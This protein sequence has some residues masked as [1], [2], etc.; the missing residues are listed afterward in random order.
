MSNDRLVMMFMI[1]QSNTLPSI[2]DSNAASLSDRIQSTEAYLDFLLDTDDHDPNS[3]AI[4][5]NRQISFGADITPVFSLSDSVTENVAINASIVISNYAFDTNTPPNTGG[6]RVYLTRIGSVPDIG[7]PQA[8]ASEFLVALQSAQPFAGVTAIAQE[9]SSRIR[10]IQGTVRDIDNKI[11]DV[12]EEEAVFENEQFI[13]GYSLQDPPSDGYNISSGPTV[14]GQ[15]SQNLNYTS[16]TPEGTNVG[17]NVMTRQFRDAVAG[18]L[19]FRFK[20]RRTDSIAGDARLRFRVVYDVPGQ[21]ALDE[22]ELV[23]GDYTFMPSQ[24]T[25]VAIPI[26]I[27][28]LAD[29]NMSFFLIFESRGTIPAG[30]VFNFQTSTG[31]SA[32]RIVEA[33]VE[34]VGTTVVGN[35]DWGLLLG[36]SQTIANIPN[37]TRTAL[38]ENFS[39]IIQSDLG[40]QNILSAIVNHEDDTVRANIIPDETANGTTNTVSGNTV[41][42]SVRLG[43]N[44]N[45]ASE[46]AVYMAST[47]LLQAGDHRNLIRLRI[48]QTGST[49]YS[50]TFELDTNN[51]LP[52]PKSPINVTGDVT[53]TATFQ[54][55]FFDISDISEFSYIDLGFTPTVLVPANT[56]FEIQMAYVTREPD[57]VNS[58]VIDVGGTEVNSGD[59]GSLLSNNEL[60]R[61]SLRYS[62]LLRSLFKSVSDPVQTTN[63]QE[64]LLLDNGAV[65][66]VGTAAGIGGIPAHRSYTSVSSIAANTETLMIDSEMLTSFDIDPTVDEVF[67]LYVNR[68][69][70]STVTEVR[71]SLEVL[72]GTTWE[73]LEGVDSSISFLPNPIVPDTVEFIPVTIDTNITGIRVYIESPQAIPTNTVFSAFVRVRREQHDSMNANITRLIGNEV[74]Q[75]QANNIVSPGGVTAEAFQDNVRI[76]NEILAKLWTGDNDIQNILP[77]AN[78]QITGNVP[79][80]VSRT[81]GDN[82]V[83]GFAIETGDNQHQEVIYSIARGGRINVNNILSIRARR[84][85]NRNYTLPNFRI[86]LVTATGNLS[87]IPIGLS[88]EG[89]EQEYLFSFQDNDNLVGRS[90]TSWQMIVSVDSGTIAEADIEFFTASLASEVSII[91]SIE[92]PQGLLYSVASKTMA[93]V[94]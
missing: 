56:E 54:D 71:F 88:L 34:E 60:I 94:N 22:G 32:R 89:S 49:F 67:T 39:R 59:W 5:E 74:T 12:T 48:R 7:D 15:A 18:V 33:K 76:T 84:N 35:N 46:I 8:L 92:R 40:I 85:G 82:N 9:N 66:S 36:Y 52:N 61:S 25:Q 53:L 78:N 23:S 87:T 50:G 16:L 17:T 27:A 63:L 51:I 79:I 57:T 58:K 75:E 47:V 20:V 43:L 21:S 38:Q 31:Y 30:S 80:T 29:R 37:L 4:L 42:L 70:P 13:A 24:T 45:A 81:T 65:F 2:D 28:P 6:F 44:A 1:T 62:S 91:E 93:G 72:S 19:V 69:T 11:D 86:R 55:L 41:T 90:F 73:R 77:T 83:L 14:D 3:L 10:Q 64:F 26:S 68:V